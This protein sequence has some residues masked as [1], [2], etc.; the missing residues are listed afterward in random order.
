VGRQELSAGT[1]MDELDNGSSSGSQLQP[2]LA[3]SFK[4]QLLGYDD[5]LFILEAYLYSGGNFHRGGQVGLGPPK[6]IV[7]NFHTNQR[8]LETVSKHMVLAS[9][10]MVLIPIVFTAH[11]C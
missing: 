6:H 2:C 8:M 1:T 9:K 7:S 3:F 11:G 5:R 10:Q 4:D